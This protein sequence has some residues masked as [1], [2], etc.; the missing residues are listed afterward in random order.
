MIESVLHYINRKE[1]TLN[2]VKR[3]WEI[4]IKE[5]FNQEAIINQIKCD[6]DLRTVL[7]NDENIR[8]A[9]KRLYDF[10]LDFQLGLQ[11]KIDA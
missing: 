7:E 11:P 5:N 3:F 8:A 4:C 6:G 9:V 10:F 1:I 2:D